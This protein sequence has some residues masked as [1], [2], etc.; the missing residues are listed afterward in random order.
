[1]G[2]SARHLSIDQNEPAHGLAHGERPV[3]STWVDA[4]AFP[5]LRRR[6]GEGQKTANSPSGSSSAKFWSELLQEANAS[7]SGA[8]TRAGKA[9]MRSPPASPARS[10]S[11]TISG[12]SDFL[13]AAGDK[14]EHGQD[15]AEVSS[16]LPAYSEAVKGKWPSLHDAASYAL[17]RPGPHRKEH[18]QVQAEVGSK[19]TVNSG[20]RPEQWP[21]R[22]DPASYALRAKPTR[23]KTDLSKIDPASYAWRG[24]GAVRTI[25]LSKIDPASYARRIGKPGKSKKPGASSSRRSG[26][27]KAS[28]DG[29]A[30]VHKP[31]D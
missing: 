31:K 9:P 6:A 18:R 3:P 16:K 30:A 22:D 4:H 5:A 25:D 26:Q 8:A 7:S 14:K 27:K 12:W 10:G 21:S 1:M 15:Q 24:K 11:P 28:G 13:A 20:A 17:Q 2:T 23:R 29:S 19:P